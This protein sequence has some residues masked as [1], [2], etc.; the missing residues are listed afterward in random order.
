MGMEQRPPFHTATPDTGRPDWTAL[1]KYL[2]GEA[3]PDEQAAVQRWIMASP[4]R[5]TTLAALRDEWASGRATP[6]MNDAARRVHLDTALDEFW[7]QAQA[8]PLA[9]V[10]RAGVPHASVLRGD[11]SGYRSPTLVRR[12][13][14]G[15]LIGLGVAAAILVVVRQRRS[16][17]EVTGGRQYVT[18][19]GQEAVLTLADGTRIQL[20]P[21]SRLMVPSDFGASRREVALAGEAYFDVSHTKGTPFIVRTGV[22]TTRVLGTAFDVAVLGDR[23][24]HN[25]IRAIRVAVMSGKVASGTG[26]PAIVSAG[27]VAHVTDSSAV[28]L[29]TTDA[30]QYTTWTTGRLVFH[31]APVA[32][33]LSRLEQWYGI[34]FH[35]TDPALQ[36]RHVTATFDTHSRSDALTVLKAVLDVTMTFEDHGDRL[37]VTMHAWN[38]TISPRRARPVRDAFTHRNTEVGR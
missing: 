31:D 11:R 2:I 13:T 20:A 16:A 37:T 28:L 25:D 23:A 12:V 5:A 18:R 10:S 9:P 14:I 15:S 4:E 24:E 29:P 34:D 38:D 26:T 36:D 27:R 33:I 8:G 19:P 6:D 17:E 22:I 7:R 3:S 32:D 21:Q 30:A 1:T 35:V